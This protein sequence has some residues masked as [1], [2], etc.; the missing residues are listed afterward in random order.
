MSGRS[1]R[2]ARW[3]RLTKM[4]PQAHG[5]AGLVLAAG[6]GRR[7]GLGAKALLR[8][9]GVTL[10]ERA[11]GALG[12]GG[13]DPVLVVVGAQAEAVAAQVPGAQ[14]VRNPH[15]PSGLASSFRAGVAALPQDAVRVVVTLVDQPGVGPQVVARLLRVHQ[16]GRITAA[17]YDESGTEAAP[18][19]RHPMVF[20]ASLVHRAAE[21][22]R[23]DHGARE[24]LRANPGLLD[25]VDCS[26]L[27]SAADIDTPADLHLL[28]P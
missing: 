11:V 23:G 16:P 6:G 3:P 8:S 27:G 10:V 28:Q 20:D 14:V 13:C 7:L 15:W 5:S 19:P 12:E 25:L 4:D 9:A 21:T 17:A 22:A 2:P 1:T 26:D 18:R 24:F